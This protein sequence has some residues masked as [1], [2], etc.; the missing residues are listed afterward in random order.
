[1]ATPFEVSAPGNRNRLYLG[2]DKIEPRVTLRSPAAN[3]H[4]QWME[5]EKARWESAWQFPA[6]EGDF[7]RRGEKALWSNEC[8][9][10]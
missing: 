9:Q 2:K 3:K 6:P 5:N 8:S 10:I 1:M 7:S 4:A